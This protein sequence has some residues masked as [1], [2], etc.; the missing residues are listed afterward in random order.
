MCGELLL[1]SLKM[2]SKLYLL[3]FAVLFACSPK[4]TIQTDK[5][6]PGDFKDYH[7]FKFFNPKNLPASNF[8]FEERD[9][10]SWETAVAFLTD[11]KS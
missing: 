7:T 8:S 9:W 6:F 1:K 2:M 11:R 3:I 4:F 5:P 10:D